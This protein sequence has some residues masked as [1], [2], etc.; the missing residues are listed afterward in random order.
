MCAMYILAFFIPDFFS[1]SVNNEF[2]KDIITLSSI[3]IDFSFTTYG[4]IIGLLSQE[5]MI[6]MKRK[7]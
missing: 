7:G 4:I 3:F 5:V 6:N 1:L 2:Y